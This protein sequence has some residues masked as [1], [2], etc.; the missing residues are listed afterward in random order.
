MSMEITDD[1][2]ALIPLSERLRSLWLFRSAAIVLVAIFA[3]VDGG[4]P[5]GG[6][7]MLA[8]A[9]AAYLL[10]VGMLEATWRLRR[11]RHL[12]LFG[13]VLI[14]DAAYLAYV[15]F[16]SSTTSP[17]YYLR[18]VQLVVVALLASYRTGLR[19]ALWHS[20]LVFLAYYLGTGRGPA[21]VGSAGLSG[22]GELAGF[23]SLLWLVTLAT[24]TFSALN[25][26]ELRRRRYDLEA[27][28][29]FSDDVEAAQF[30]DDIGALYV[31]ALSDTFGFGRILLIGGAHDEMSLIASVGC[32]MAPAERSFTGHDASVVSTALRA[33]RTRLV[34]GLDPDVDEWLVR[35][36]PEPGNLIIA[37]LSSDKR[38][39]GVA[40]IEHSL[41]RGSRVEQ[42]VVAAAE[43]FTAHVALALE[44]AWL[45]AQVR[46]VAATDGLTGLAN[47]SH[48]DLSL[49][50][51]LARAIRGK[52]PASLLLVDIDFFK[53]LNDEYGHQA[54]DDV[55]RRVA[56]II[57]DSARL[58]DTAAR[59][60]GEEFAVILAAAGVD[61]A[62]AAADRLRLAIRD[63]DIGYAVTVS[64]G[65][66]SFPEHGTT[67]FEMVRAADE[68]LYE[69]KS[70][71]RNQ[72]VA[73]RPRLAVVS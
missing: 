53:R 20:A 8:A 63:A 45:L 22:Y 28:A 10:V 58:G 43:R 21:D 51:Q 55:L 26:R 9:T 37:P 25:E 54:G 40:V 52:E 61:E 32:T 18:V 36:M 70:A 19:L 33:R 62:V 1:A 66:A 3:S 14:V 15:A 48:F 29:K 11:G 17:L 56:R 13:S 24:T 65:V 44:N 38:V 60:G 16:G 47:R 50:Q 72:V 41:P 67:G 31:D 30:A 64:I 2:Q 7:G 57:A 49:E 39:I 73:A 69:A 59:Y 6:L 34:R 23:I 27:L 71:G 4:R 46:R 42:R 5:V 12:R 68:A 35:A